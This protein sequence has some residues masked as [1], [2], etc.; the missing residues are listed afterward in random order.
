MRGPEQAGLNALAGSSFPNREAGRSCESELVLVSTPKLPPPL[1][2]TFQ[3]PLPRF[4]CL[5][6]SSRARFALKVISLT[7]T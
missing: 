1:T 3:L 7:Q 4:L 2:F 6:G 5:T